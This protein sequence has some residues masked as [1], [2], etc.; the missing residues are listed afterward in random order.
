LP[1]APSPTSSGTGPPA[2]SPV[3]AVVTGCLPSR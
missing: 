2:R 1:K 3:S